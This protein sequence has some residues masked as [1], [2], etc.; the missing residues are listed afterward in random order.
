MNKLKIHFFIVAF[1]L[2]L[3]PQSIYAQLNSVQ[4]DSLL[5]DAMQKFNVVGASVGIV[6]DGKIIHSKGYGL[7]SIDKSD[8]VNENTQFCIASNSKAFAATAL[9]IL[10]EEGKLSW[11]DKVRDYIPNFKMYN[12]YVTENFNIEDLLTH[13]SG[14]GLG[15]GDLMIFP[16]GSDFTIDDIAQNFQYMKPQSAFRTKFDYDNLLYLIAGEITAKVSGMTW[17]GFVEKRILNPLEM[18]HSVSGINMLTDKRELASPH[19]TVDNKNHTIPQ[20]QQM[21]NGAAAGIYSSSNDISKWMLVHLNQGKYGENLEQTLFSIESQNQMWK[22]QTTTRVNRNPR[23]NSHF[24]GYGLG[25]NLTD[26]LGNMKISHTGGMP[27]MLSKITL[28]PDLNLGLV[29]LTNTSDG[30]ALLFETV[31]NSI[32]DSYLGLDDFKW[33]DKYYTYFQTVKQQTDSIVNHVWKTVRKNKN[34]SIKTEDYIGVFQDQW[35][36]KVEIFM[37]KN[38]L[39]FKSYRSP[40]LNG[41]VYFYQANTFAI[42]W[43]YQDMNADAFAIFSLD[44]NGRAQGITMKG[45]SPDIDFSFDFQDLSFSRIQK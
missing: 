1:S 13:R 10:V 43:E 20:Y 37:K 28:I 6:K 25:F 45:I 3:F 39:W 17:E 4:I 38:Q 36:G 2:L 29:I 42:K 27:G 44:E 9:S 11:Q 8:K 14:L 34:N 35:F 30:G 19:A 40:K 26:V 33:V 16:D 31:S 41:P 18:N 7:K 21:L 24:A 23:Y 5:E 15:A 12:A 32:I 22:I